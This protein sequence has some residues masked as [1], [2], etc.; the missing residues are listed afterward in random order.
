MSAIGKFQIIPAE[1]LPGL[2]AE[3]RGTELIAEIDRKEALSIEYGYDGW[4]LATL[5]PV[6]ATDYGINLMDADRSLSKKLSE[7][8][9]IT[10]F[11]FTP[12]ERDLSGK[13]DPALFESLKLQSSYEAFND[14]NAD[15]VGEAMIAGITFLRSGLE[16][17]TAETIGILAIG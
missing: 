9:G 4:V 16:A 11:V 12:K 6:L 14:V 1:L 17:V 10:V 3:I 8:S 13:L 5:L 7:R 2:E 15:G